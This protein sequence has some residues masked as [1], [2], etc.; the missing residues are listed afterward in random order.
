MPR[1]YSRRRRRR[2]RR[3]RTAAR[4]RRQAAFGLGRS[5]FW[6][7]VKFPIAEWPIPADA[8]RSKVYRFFPFYYTGATSD[9]VH[10][11]SMI[12]ADPR[13]TAMLRCYSQVR[14]INMYVSITALVPGV[15][16]EFGAVSLC[17]RIIRNCTKTTPAT[18]FLDS[19]GFI[20]VP[21][22]VWKR[23]PGADGLTKLSLTVFPKGTVEN[24]QWYPTVID[25]QNRSLQFFVD[26]KVSI[27]A[28]AIDLAVIVTSRS[29]SLRQMP[30]SIFYRCTYEFRNADEA[31]NE[32]KRTTFTT[33]AAIEAENVLAEHQ[34]AG[35]TLDGTTVD[36]Y[37]MD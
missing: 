27:F 21:G 6:S 35:L 36:G 2:Y 1:R 17:G 18:E 20:S 31:G 14:L 34:T 37:S 3:Y 13:F 8:Y 9:L 19:S 16:E 25:S 32:T 7:S 12:S 11:A 26:G 4:A 29:G 15:N 23:T 33:Q 28:P 22:I 24:S 30:F 10:A 5:R